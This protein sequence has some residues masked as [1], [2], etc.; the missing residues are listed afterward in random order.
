MLINNTGSQ[1]WRTKDQGRQRK[2]C[3][4]AGGLF[5]RP[6]LLHKLI[7]VQTLLDDCADAFISTAKNASM[8]GQPVVVGMS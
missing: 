5:E 6:H 1:L 2:G 8:T 3:L 7:A 4:E